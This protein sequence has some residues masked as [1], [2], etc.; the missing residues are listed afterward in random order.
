MRIFVVGNS[1]PV[2]DHVT[3]ESGTGIVHTAPGHGVEDFKVCMDNGIEVLVPVNDYG[4]FT[5]EAGERFQGKFVLK[6]GNEEVLKT[7][8]EV[9]A[10]VHFSEYKHKYPYDWRTKVW[11]TLGEP[12]R[13][14]NRSLLEQQLNGL[15]A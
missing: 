4:K 11:K 15:P 8:K 13:F 6:E 3:L 14:R 2:G 9:N 1:C 12:K 5:A 7:L 10:L